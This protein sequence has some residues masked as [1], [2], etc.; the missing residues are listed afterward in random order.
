MQNIDATTA[1][2]ISEQ[3]RIQWKAE[4]RYARAYYYFLLL[5]SYGPIMLVG[6]EPIDF[7]QNVATL[8]YMRN[9][10]Q[11]CADYI[12]KEMTECAAVLPLEQDAIYWGKPT[13]GAALS[14]IA[15]LKL[16]SAR[17]LFNGCELYAGIANPD[18]TKL[19]PTYD[20]NR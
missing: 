11:E 1:E 6:D 4:A 7:N 14:V 18:G 3:E 9:T 13:K 15:R 10:Y 12:T 2:D 20:K 5:R 16:Y 19:F 17:P 8:S